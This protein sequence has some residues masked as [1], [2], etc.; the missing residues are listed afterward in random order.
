MEE[1]KSYSTQT[2]TQNMI[3]DLIWKITQ[4]EIK[5][6]EQLP[7]NDE[8]AKQYNVGRST[9]REAI[10]Q[11]ESYGFVQS[12]HGRGTFILD[13]EKTDNGTN[14]LEEIID[15]RR[16]IEVHS[17]KKTVKYITFTQLQ[18][19]NNLLME[20]ENCIDNPQRFTDIDREFHVKITVF[21]KSPFLPK[22]FQNISGF[23]AG[24]QDSIVYLPGSPERAIVEHK[25]MIEALKNKDEEKA[26]EVINQ[27]LD[28]VV[29]QI[30]EKR[31][32]EL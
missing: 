6:G 24:V 4:N 15:L 21:S 8:L 17:I 1:V 20:M 22:M 11:I 26:V 2:F 7:S 29:T 5:P 31:V 16:M 23:F 19:L 12:T 27:H 14:L 30:K 25:C 9:I 18:E 32:K 13:F 3:R 10:K 28:S